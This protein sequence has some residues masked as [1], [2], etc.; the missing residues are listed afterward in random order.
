MCL[1]FIYHELWSKH[2]FGE[3]VGFL[4]QN[5]ALLE[6][7][8]VREN[9]EMIKK[10]SRTE[11]SIEEALKKVALS[12]AV[13]KKIYKISGG[14]QQRVAL[15]R[16]MIKKCS[17]ILADEPTGSLDAENSKIVMD[18]LHDFNRV[19]KTVLIVTHSQEIVDSEE[20]VITLSHVTR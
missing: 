19:G 3:V 4:F 7:K 12:S 5:F 13:N 15:A 1:R 20:H 6:N 17:L 14:E 8:T 16:L 2:Y 9:L 10:S 11:I 18:I